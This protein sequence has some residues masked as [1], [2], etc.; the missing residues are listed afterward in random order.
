MIDTTGV[1]AMARAGLS[2]DAQLTTPYDDP[3]SVVLLCADEI[4]R[5]RERNKQVEEALHHTVVDS[6]P[7]LESMGGYVIQPDTFGKLAALYSPAIAQLQALHIKA[8]GGMVTGD[9]VAAAIAALAQ[10]KLKEGDDGSG[11]DHQG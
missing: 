8:Q 6:L 1:R 7:A 10:V 5:L 9:D 4:D 2:S 3:A 11:E